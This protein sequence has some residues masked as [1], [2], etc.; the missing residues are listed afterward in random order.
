MTGVLAEIKSDFAYYLPRA[1]VIIWYIES[2]SIKSANEWRVAVM[3][4]ARKNVEGDEQWKITDE[5]VA[6][7]GRVLY[8]AAEGWA[9]WKR[10][11]V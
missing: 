1:K 8:V 7:E 2:L 4:W 9:H 11:E 6:G 3:K 5:V 10:Q